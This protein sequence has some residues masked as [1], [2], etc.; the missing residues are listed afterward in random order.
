MHREVKSQE[1]KV[2][3]LVIP[4]GPITVDHSVESSGR[5]G[6]RT[7]RPTWGDAAL[8]PGDIPMG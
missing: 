6:Q 4:P 7:S 2:G 1:G 5:S 3:R 8:R